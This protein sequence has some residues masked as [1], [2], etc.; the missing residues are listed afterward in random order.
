MV[1][2]HCAT[3]AAGALDVRVDAD[4]EVPAEGLAGLDETLHYLEGEPEDVARYVLILDA[5]N[6]G[7]GWFE[8][9]K[10]GTN[11]LTERL[12]A[13]T[14]E[15][16]GPWSAAELRELR[17]GD[18]ADALSLNAQHELTR[19]YAQALNQLGHRLGE[20][21]ALALAG[22]SAEG[23]AERLAISLPFFADHGFFKRAQIAANDLHLSGAVRYPDTAKLTAFADNLV[24]HV[25][26]HDGVLTY[27]DTLA[28]LVDEGREL[29]AGSRYEREIRACGVHSCELLARRLEVAP[30]T[31]DNWLWNRGQTIPGRPHRTRT[32]FY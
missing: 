27:S 4:R 8:E 22:D 11:V 30:A 19:L 9:L 25:L 17:A 26:R 23:L 32:V 6:F 5:I 28:A 15:R 31:L 2:R 20:A 12:T 7:S 29:P 16:G 13:L 24:P 10:T 21:G 3:V 1:R 14:R 18:V